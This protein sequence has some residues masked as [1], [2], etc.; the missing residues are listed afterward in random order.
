MGTHNPLNDDDDFEI[1][2]GR[3]VLK[4]GRALRFDIGL[5]DTAHAAGRM[6]FTD[7]ADPPKSIDEALKRT[8]EEQ[9]KSAG[10][11]PSEWL[12]SRNAAQ[13]EKLASEVATRFV[14]AAGGAGVAAAFAM[15]GRSASG[16][17][18]IHDAVHGRA[19]STAMQDA[20]AQARTAATLAKIDADPNRAW[21]NDPNV[22]AAEAVRDAA[23]AW[24]FN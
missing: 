6:F 18:A 11:K 9:A 1:V 2:D 20:L 15:D 14:Q 22:K 10:M 23:R 12:A 7:A 5:M 8:V 3:P 13:M 16:A 17:Q 19:R 4:S 24:R 21:R